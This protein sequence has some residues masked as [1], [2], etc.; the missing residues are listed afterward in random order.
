MPLLFAFLISLGLAAGLALF[1]AGPFWQGTLAFFVVLVPGVVVLESAIAQAEEG[2]LARRVGWGS[3]LIRLALG[4]GLYLGLSLYGYPNEQERAGYIFTDAYNRDRQAWELAQSGRP[5]RDAFQQRFYADQY[6]GLLAISAALYRYLSPHAH[7]PL[8]IVA[9]VAWVGA[10][11]GVYF[12]QLAKRLLPPGA[13]RAATWLFAFYP[14]ALLLGASQM[15]EPFLLTF[16]TLFFLGVMRVREGHWRFRWEAI[17]GIGGLLL[18]SPV[19]ALTFG[20]ALGFWLWMEEGKRLPAWTW[21]GLLVVILAGAV[22]FAASVGGLSAPK[23]AFWDVIREWSR[24]TVR[25]GAYQLE[26]SSGWVQKLFREMPPVLQL[27]FVT[28]YG[29]LQP[30]LP[31]ALVEPALPIRK[32]IAI[33]RALGWYTLLPLLLFASSAVWKT[34]APER[35]R[36]MAFFLIVWTWIVIAA[37]RGGGDQWD[38][39][40]Y[41]LFF[42]TFQALLAIYAWEHRNQWWPRVL[43]IEAFAILVFLQWYLSRYYHLGGRLPFPAMIGLILTFALAVLLGGWFWD[44]K[45]AGERSIHK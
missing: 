16:G 14:E 6:G 42:L 40:R 33:G 13:A 19:T 21:I 37:L 10:L 38:T 3:L 1:Q 36:W 2:P 41:R 28:G 18:I 23:G 45:K 17:L 26:R 15:R 12:W 31:A 8:L 22:L 39:P 43:G 29:V 11:G 20:L 34:P 4:L 35:R 9:L 27:P 25:W 32:G 5:L 24:L 44:R 7:R 30:I